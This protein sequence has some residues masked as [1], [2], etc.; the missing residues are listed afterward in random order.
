MTTLARLLVSAVAATMLVFIATGLVL[1]YFDQPN[2][3]PVPNMV[4]DIEFASP[5][6]LVDLG[7]RS[8]ARE[9]REPP[10]LPELP[11]RQVSGFVQLEFT[12]NPDGSV[13]DVKVVGAVPQGYYE[14]QA[15]EIVSQRR[16]EPTLEDGEFVART[17]TDVV[18]FT[19]PADSKARP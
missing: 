11:P 9:P 15:R 6:S 16:Y 17:E 8:N 5:D 7:I 10:P 4:E 18:E 3:D 2:P 19:V 14:A 13:S 1:D 12:V